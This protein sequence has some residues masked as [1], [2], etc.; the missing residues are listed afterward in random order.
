MKNIFLLTAKVFKLSSVII[1]LASAHVFAGGNDNG[2]QLSVSESDSY[3]N[4]LTEME[5][6][7]NKVE[8]MQNILTPN[9]QIIVYDSSYNLIKAT[10]IPE[11]GI[12]EDRE[13][14]TLLRQSSELMKLEHITYYVLDK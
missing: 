7:L 5:K 13:V 4:A 12:V 3:A 11:D 2:V 14:L 1:I 10:D 9:P 6:A 8:E